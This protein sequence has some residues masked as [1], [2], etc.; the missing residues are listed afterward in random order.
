MNRRRA[1]ALILAVALAAAVGLGCGAGDSTDGTSEA[2]AEALARVRAADFARGV[3]LR[4][5][6]VPYFEVQPDEE[7][8]PREKR[9]Q[10]RELQKCIGVGDSEES[11]AAVDS[12]TYGT[13]SPGEFLDVASSVEIVGGAGEAARQ[14]QLVRSRRA[15]SCM[16]RVY[17]SA[18]RQDES[19]TAEVRGASVARAR[20]PAPGI[21]DS[22]AYRFTASVTVHAPTSQLS[23]YRPAA[24]PDASQT[25]KAYVDILGFAVGP[26][27]VTLTATG[28]PAPVS[29]NLERNLIGVLHQRASERRP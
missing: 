13:E 25:L 10:D 22:F 1:P 11:L 20:F 12:P 28:I 2:S 21:Q 17:A 7:E 19:S 5:S 4:A 26:V 6:D 24:E 23:A 16:Q 29:R 27:E 9:R 18:L 8:D 3:N 14:L 15:E